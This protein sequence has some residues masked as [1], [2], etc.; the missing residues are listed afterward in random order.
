MAHAILSPS[1]ASR[2]L[3]CT[4][5][6]RLESTFPDQAGLAAR[7]GTLAHTLGELL[8]RRDNDW[9]TPPKFDKQLALIKADKL[10]Q[11]EMMAYCEDYAAYI[12]E[13]FAAAKMHTADAQLL[14][15]QRV[16]L[17]DFIKEGFGTTDANIIADH[18]LDITDLKYGKG[19]PVSAVENKQMM[20]YALGSLKAF[21]HLYDIQVVR[22]T[23]YQPRIQNISSWEISVTDL[24]AWAET[25]L[26]PKAALAFTG[27]GDFLPGKHCQFCRARAV[28]KTNAAFNLEIEEYERRESDLLSDSDIADILGRAEALEKWLKAV[29]D[30]ALQQAVAGKSY[31]GYKL[32]EG[33]SVRKYADEAAVEKRLRDNGFTDAQ[34]FKPLE[35]LGITALQGELGKK[36]FEQL[37]SPLIIKPAGKPV[38]VPS[39]DK[40]P[41]LNNLEAAVR[42]FDDGFED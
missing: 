17:T 37:L 8:I 6:A 18:T 12:M 32:V 9:V 11:N 29:K 30:H 7:E 40:R 4:P 24:L 2:W 1:G 25:E 19:V 16:D 22:M 39:S 10:Y 33:R 21:G 34:I 31:P 20:I 41:E 26:R 38:L 15:E 36:Q 27:E 3:A 42:D 14:L 35:L 23:I 13:K 28:C 5:S